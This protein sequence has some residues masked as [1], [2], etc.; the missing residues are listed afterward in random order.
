MSLGNVQSL[1]SQMVISN[2][3]L[4]L[5]PDSTTVSGTFVLVMLPSCTKLVMRPIPAQHINGALGDYTV[6]KSITLTNRIVTVTISGSDW[7]AVVSD[8][9]YTVLDSSLPATTSEGGTGLITTGS[10]DQI[11][12]VVHTGVGLQYKTVSGTGGI[13]ITPGN[14][15]LVVDGSSLVG[16]GFTAQN[17]SSSFTAVA[18]FAYFVSAT[19][20]VTLPTA[21]GVAGKSVVVTNTGSAQTLT[22]NTTSAQ[23]MNGTASG[24]VTN[25]TQYNRLTFLSDG[26]NWFYTK[27]S[28]A[29]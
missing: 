6:T 27:T 7:V 1:S 21:V 17:K 18:N 13:V 2:E 5:M 28:S 22:F 8:D 4:V 25:A 29:D 14:G 19:S 20:T 15:T 24:G 10:A 26:A 11:L 12:G 23:T 9:A 3:D 16:S